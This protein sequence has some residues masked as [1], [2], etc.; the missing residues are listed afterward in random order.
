M[1]ANYDDMAP[2]AIEEILRYASPVIHFRRTV[3]RDGVTLTDA[4]G[5]VTHTF[6]AGDKV[7]VWYPAANRDPAVF[8]SRSVFDIA[9]KPNNHI[10]FGGP[11]PHFCLGAHLARLELNVAFRDAV[12]ALP[13]HPRGGRTRH[14]EV[15]LRQRHQTPEGHLHADEHA[16][17]ACCPTS[18]KTAS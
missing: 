4:Q 5:E 9:R 15:E 16:G 17:N 11:G 8:D 13:R 1:L 14:A 12:R 10:A 18:R 2:T 3:T 7:V 6:N